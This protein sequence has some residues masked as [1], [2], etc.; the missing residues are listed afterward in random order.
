MY[1]SGEPALQP[2]FTLAIRGA[3]PANDEE[4]SDVFLGRKA[5]LA[6]EL[7]HADSAGR[8]VEVALA[9]LRESLALTDEETPRFIPREADVPAGSAQVVFEIPAGGPRPHGNVVIATDRDWAS[10]P[11]AEAREILVDLGRALDHVEARADASD[12]PRLHEALAR[13]DAL[14]REAGES[15]M[16]D[17]HEVV[18]V[19][20]ELERRDA[21]ILEELQQALR[22]QK[23]MIAGLPVHRDVSSSSLYLPAETI[24]GDFYD[25]AVLE[26]DVVR[27]FIADATGHGVA[28]GLATMFIKS[29]YEARKLRET[30]PAALLRA[31]NERLA[32]SYR[33]LELQFT[34]VCMDLRPNERR[35]CYATAAHPGPILVRQGAAKSM[36]SGGTFV[37]VVTGVDFP[38]HEVSLEPG[39]LVV[40]FTDGLLDA[41]GPGG[42]AFGEA[43]ITDV[44]SGAKGDPSEA[45]AA[46]VRSL[47][48]FLGESHALRDDVT[49]VACALRTER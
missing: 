33:N 29:E 19:V 43:R 6:R 5:S 38:E 3:S 10:S 15:L 11:S 21:M 39:D 44:L 12:V 18:R 40:A 8:A 20:A 24:S 34:A 42:E 31:M 41:E 45:S 35:L 27:I 4:S 25:V 47:S 16:R 26:P 13:R 22:F 7:L 30:S 48:R 2:S 37:G 49:V 36:P 28:A 17:A 23:A 1:D 9:A 14:V 46:L 32:S